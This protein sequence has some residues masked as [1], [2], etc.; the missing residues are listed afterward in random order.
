MAKQTYVVLETLPDGVGWKIIKMV[1]VEGRTDK[2]RAHA[3]VGAVASSELDERGSID[4]LQ[5]SWAA[6]SAT[7]FH[8]FGVAEE[9]R[10]LLRPISYDPK[11]E[12]L[13]VD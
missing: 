7:H 6:V 10:L 4:K 11:Q 12:T 9:R 13:E 5:T 2:D 3:A 1:D 8:W